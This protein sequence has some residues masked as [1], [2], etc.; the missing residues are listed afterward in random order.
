MRV[1]CTKCGDLV[2]TTA[3]TVVSPF[4]CLPC[5]YGSETADS[6]EGG[7]FDQWYDDMAPKSEDY[8]D[9]PGLEPAFDPELGEATVEN[10]TLLIADL[11]AQLVNER[12]LGLAAIADLEKKLESSAAWVAEV[13]LTLLNR[14]EG[15]KEQLAN[16]IWESDR[17]TRRIFQLTL[18]IYE[19]KRYFQ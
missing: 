9:T 1:E 17:K 6:N 15:L 8:A 12:A 19:Q 10:T 4:I 7:Y 14:I 18:Q 3:A 13:N 2:D 11:E 5:G 16:A